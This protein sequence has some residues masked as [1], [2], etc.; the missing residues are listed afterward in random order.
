MLPDFYDSSHSEI[1]H[2]LCVEGIS[3]LLLTFAP[4]LRRC[5]IV[6]RIRNQTQ[7][8]SYNSSFE[9]LFS[10]IDLLYTPICKFFS[11]FYMA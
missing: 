11:N 3:K 7:L 6:Y 5:Y 9:Y 10:R 1:Y 2:N 8:V 4:G